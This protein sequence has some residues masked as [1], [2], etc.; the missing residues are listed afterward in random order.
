[1]PGKRL[2]LVAV[3][4]AVVAELVLGVFLVVRGGGTPAAPANPN[5]YRVGEG[6]PIP[7]PCSMIDRR[8]VEAV[9]GTADLYPSG[10]D[11]VDDNDPIRVC[12]FAAARIELGEVTVTMTSHLGNNGVLE[13]PALGISDL[14]LSDN[15]SAYEAKR[16]QNR[17]GIRFEIDNLDVT[18]AYVYPARAERFQPSP[19]EAQRIRD[20]LRALTN[21][22]AA[23]LIPRNRTGPTLPTIP[24]S[25][26]STRR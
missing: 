8:L 17:A 14:V 22:I 20:S 18:V 3:G 4:A 25:T 13:I 9:P 7:P 21:Q 15:L 1:M 16:S 11:R 6:F 19:P 5:P 2:Q 24:P 23:Q 12:R 10:S 26:R